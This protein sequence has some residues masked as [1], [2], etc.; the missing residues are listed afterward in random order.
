MSSQ[1][2]DAIPFNLHWEN[3]PAEWNIDNSQTLHITAGAKT[4]LFA[5]PNGTSITNNSPRFT[6]RPQGDFIL[7]ARVTVAFSSKY[8]AG[9]LLI[10]AHERQWAKFCFEFSP[11]NRPTVVSVVT[12]ETSDDCNSM[13]VD[14]N[15]I[16]LRI[17]R[18][19]NTFAF[20]ASDDAHFWNMIRYFTLGELGEALVGFCAQSPT[21]ESCTVTFDDIHF[22]ARTLTDLRSGE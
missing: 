22:E 21:G 9:V 3:P 2:L 19:G 20:H 5:D 4:D 17:A 11:Q 7:S 13:S 14:G 6:F 16:Y 18:V 8:D 1:R 12:R 10:Y 15:Q